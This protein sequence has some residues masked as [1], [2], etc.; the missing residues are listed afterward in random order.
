MLISPKQKRILSRKLKSLTPEELGR[1]VSTTGETPLQDTI[2]LLSRKVICLGLFTITT[3]TALAVYLSVLAGLKVRLDNIYAV[4]MFLAL[5]GLTIIF[6]LKTLK[7]HLKL[8]HLLSKKEEPWKLIGSQGGIVTA[9][10]PK[11]NVPTGL[12]R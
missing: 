4:I 11:V 5:A 7:A 10:K 8:R 12:Q 2:L 6:A 1:N 3:A 9:K